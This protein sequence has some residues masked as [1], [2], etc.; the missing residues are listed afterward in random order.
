MQ[1]L[2]G[3]GESEAVF[4]ID[5]REPD[6]RG[7]DGYPRNFGFVVRM[8][9]EW[10]IVLDYLPHGHAAQTRSH[11]VAQVLGEE[12][13]NL[14]EVVPREGVSLTIGERVYIGADRRDKIASVKEKI[15]SNKLTNSAQAE[16]EHVLQEIVNKNE[17]KFLRFFNEAAPVTTKLHSLELLPGIGKKHMWQILDERKKAPFQSFEELKKRVPLL[18]D[19]KKAIVKRISDEL[20]GDEKWYIFVSPPKR[21]FDERY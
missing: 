4:A 1:D 20:S 2:V 10:A 7:F 9:D 15:T 17:A 5:R 11:P 14:L 8:R 18:P 21:E 13:F 19:P 3:S 6:R 16:L 12:Y